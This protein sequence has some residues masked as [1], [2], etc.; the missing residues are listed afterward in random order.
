MTSVV[1]LELEGSDLKNSLE[2]LDNQGWNSEKQSQ[3][4]QNR[5]LSPEDLEPLL[6]LTSQQSDT[7]YFTFINDYLLRLIK[8]EPIMELI[9]VDIK[10]SAGEI[11]P[12]SVT[13]SDN[14]LIIVK[15]IDQAVAN[16]SAQ[17][18]FLPHCIYV[19]C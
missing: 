19:S 13:G 9:K 15:M 6:K 16:S 1:F 12:M 2:Q 18:G 10:N 14:G 8:T 4:S 11:Q 3:H 5:C 17:V 7:L